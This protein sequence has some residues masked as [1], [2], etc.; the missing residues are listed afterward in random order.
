MKKAKTILAFTLMLMVSV[1]FCG[2][3]SAGAATKNAIKAADWAVK[4]AK[5][6]S[7]TYGNQ[8]GQCHQ[9]NKKYA[10][11]YRNGS[12]VRAAYAHGAGDKVMKKACAEK[13][14]RSA[15]TLYKAMKS[16]KKYKTDWVD[17]G[18]L[19]RDKMQK[20]DVVF[21]HYGERKP[22]LL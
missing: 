10:K 12:F 17:K 2:A 1:M 6:D 18:K 14:L 4:I 20:G 19:S 16:N 11:Q 13:E 3:Y 8:K 21:Y 15:A 5:N 9:C 7:Y 22:T